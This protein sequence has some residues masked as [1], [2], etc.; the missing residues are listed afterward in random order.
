MDIKISIKEND[1]YIGAMI[2][3][4]A[5]EVDGP[6]SVKGT[7]QVVL[8]VE[9]YYTFHFSTEKKVES[10]KELLQMYIPTEWCSII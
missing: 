4:L 10:F 5:F 3:A 9:G 2:K 8:Q 7:K 6:S 1:K